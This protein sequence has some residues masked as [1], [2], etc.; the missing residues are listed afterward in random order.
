MPLSVSPACRAIALAKAGASV[1]NPFSLRKEFIQHRHDRA[2]ESRQP[3]AAPSSCRFALTHNS[4]PDP[5]VFRLPSLSRKSALY[6]EG[7]VRYFEDDYGLYQE[8]AMRPL[9]RITVDP[10]VMGG[11]PCIRNLRITVG[12]IVGLIGAGRTTEE[13]LD[14]YPYLEREDIL[15]ALSYAAW[16]AEEIEVSLAS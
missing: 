14:A 13:V 5:V 4:S 16:R 2:G 3:R 10:Q 1:A 9:K 7:L 12:T 6:F 11:K 15:E 8:A